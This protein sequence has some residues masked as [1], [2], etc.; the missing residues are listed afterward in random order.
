MFRPLFELGKCGLFANIFG[1]RTYKRC[2]CHSCHTFHEEDEEADCL[3]E[4][5]VCMAKNVY[6]RRD[7]QMELDLF[8]S[9]YSDGP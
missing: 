5:N 7:L 6:G 8:F 4:L 2:L 9:Q 3:I 1:V